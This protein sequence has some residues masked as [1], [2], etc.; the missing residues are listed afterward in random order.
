MHYIQTRSR[1]STYTET[2]VRHVME[3]V[4]EDMLNLAHR[5]FLSYDRASEWHDDLSYLLNAQA[6]CCFEVQL[7]RPNKTKA[8]WRYD[9]KDDGSILSDLDSG[10]LNLYG[11]PD[12]TEA[13][14]LVRYR[15][16][17]PNKEQVRAEM[18]KRGW[19]T[20]G[21]FIKGSSTRDRDYSKDGYGVYRSRV[22]TWDD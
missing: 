3:K 16:N 11:L 13:S 4:Y 14:L 10:G 18:R 8:G 22:G 9:L 6:I 1:T 21:S 20:G 5:G 19:T 2:R 15:D 7:H 17:H 12:D